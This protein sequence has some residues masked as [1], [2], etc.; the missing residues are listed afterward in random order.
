MSFDPAE[1][2]T[3]PSIMLSLILGLDL[4][5]GDPVYRLHPVR[6][7]G[8]L[9]S[10]YESRV[11][12]IG[13][14][15]KFG[16]IILVLI[17]LF[18]VLALSMSVS[19]WLGSMHWSLSWLWSMYLGWSFMALRDLL[20]HAEHIANAMEKENLS[21]AIWQVGMLV[22]RDTKQMG[23]PACG[24]ATVESFSDNLNDGVIAPLFFFCLFGIQWMLLFKVV[25]TLDSMIG[26]Q[27]DRYKDFGRF[28][29]KLDDFLNILPARISWLLLSATAA[30]LPGYSGINAFKV[31]WRDHAKL[32]SLNAGWCEATVAGALNIRLCGPIW[33]EG[34]LDHNY[35]L[36]SQRD[37]E[38]AT[39]WD[40]QLACRLALIT[41]LIG[42]GV[43]MVLL[44]LT[45]F[46][47]FF[48]I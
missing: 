23:F 28:A 21:E 15:G 36:G 16:G 41:T 5:F 11:Q 31:G 40:I 10:W 14:D 37:R 35:W 7:I 22:G 18:S 39:V 17:L 1:L 42:S 44:W 25:S 26:Y 20:V 46:K 33:R 24:R 8:K 6:L 19:S 12:L 47:P 48:N 3:H 2:V 13:L 4:L 29:A 30:L 32:P 43:I 27:N 34:K 38:G 9:L 45:E